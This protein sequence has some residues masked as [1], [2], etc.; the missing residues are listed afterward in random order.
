MHPAGKQPAPVQKRLRPGQV[1]YLMEDYVN[2]YEYNYMILYDYIVSDG[3]FRCFFLFLM[4]TP[5]EC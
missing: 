1:K 3:G 2:I 4:G 5:L